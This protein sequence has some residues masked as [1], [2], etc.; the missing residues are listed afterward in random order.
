MLVKHS[1]MARSATQKMLQQFAPVTM[2]LKRDL[3]DK[4]PRARPIRTGRAGVPARKNKASR[5]PPARSSRD[6][7]RSM[8]CIGGDAEN[9]KVVSCWD[10]H[11]PIGRTRIDPAARGTP[12]SGAR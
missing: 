10:F 2:V 8:P 3:S 11:A 5:D 4:A 1:F 9:P 12:E 6:D 7:R